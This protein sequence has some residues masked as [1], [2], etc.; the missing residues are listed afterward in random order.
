MTVH[1]ALSIDITVSISQMRKLML[2]CKEV[3]CSGSHIPKGQSPDLH[4][5]L[6]S[7]QRQMGKRTGNKKQRTINDMQ[8]CVPQRSTYPEEV[9]ADGEVML[10]VAVSVP[11]LLEQG[12]K[13]SA[14]HQEHLALLGPPDRQQELW[15]LPKGVW[16]RMKQ[17]ETAPG[18]P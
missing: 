5:C 4:P 2:K 9:E 18:I 14:W 12:H 16:D 10:P 8:G 17:G 11:G 3:T 6:G 15:V 7:R 1:S 13:H